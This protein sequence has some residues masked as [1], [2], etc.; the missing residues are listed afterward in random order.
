MPPSV[1]TYFMIATSNLYPTRDLTLVNTKTTFLGPNKDPQRTPKPPED[2]YLTN[3]WVN[4]CTL[5]FQIPVTVSLFRNSDRSPSSSG[6]FF[7]VT[8]YNLVLGW[9]VR[10]SMA[11]DVPWGHETT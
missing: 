3:L 4:L 8:G 6:G 10:P 2:S 7:T 5:G 1:S 9:M 11:G